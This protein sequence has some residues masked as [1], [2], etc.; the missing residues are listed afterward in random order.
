MINLILTVLG[1]YVILTIC[2]YL[3][4]SFLVYF[5]DKKIHFSPNQ[6][7]LDYEDINFTTQ[8]GVDLNGWFIAAANNYTLLFCHG[9]AGNISHRL[10]SIYIFNQLGLNVF[11]FDYRG[12]GKSGGSISELGSY[13]DA[14]AAWQYLLQKRNI[15]PEKIIIFGR[16]LGSGVASWLAREK[17]PL[18][19]IIESSFISIPELARKHY[20]IFPV[21]LLAR[22]KYPVNDYIQHISSAKLVI[23]SIDDELIPYQHGQKNFQLAPEP[24][25]FL[26]IHGSHNNAFLVSRDEYV[27]GIKTFLRSISRTPKKIK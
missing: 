16:S 27:T 9:N 19:I 26:S 18:A 25:K 2:L 8:D 21:K 7:G 14:E 1:I 23:H 10:E 4:Q 12:F 20:P 22:I 15:L 24:K 17:N 13:A 5:P 6:V 3:F 11:I